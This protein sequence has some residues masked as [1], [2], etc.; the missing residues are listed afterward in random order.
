MERINEVLEYESTKTGGDKKLSGD[1]YEIEAKNL[2]FAYPDASQRV[3]ND[4]SFD[5]KSGETLG[6]IGGTGSGKS[7]LL[8]LLLQ[9]YEPGEGELFLNGIDIKTLNNY[10]V[11]DKI[12]YV[13][14]ENFFFSKTVA[15]NLSYA[16]ELS[17]IHI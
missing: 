14:Q 3:L 2:S 1:I 13:P 5:V 10:Q 16:K 9:F 6:I 15:E 17:L 4:I 11:R 7:S 12:S 8:R